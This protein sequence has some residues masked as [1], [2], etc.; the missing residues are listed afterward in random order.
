[1]SCQSL[2]TTR[3]SL[4]RLLL[5]LLL[6]Q[7]L[8]TSSSGGA[9][10]LPL[11]LAPPLDEGEQLQGRSE[12]RATTTTTKAWG[13]SLDGGGGDE[14]TSRRRGV[15]VPPP[16]R[17]SSLLPGGRTV[18]HRTEA[19]EGEEATLAQQDVTARNVR[20]GSDSNDGTYPPDKSAA[21]LLLRAGAG[22]R[23]YQNKL[24]V[25]EGGPPGTHGY[26]ASLSDPRTFVPSSFLLATTWPRR[27]A[28]MRRRRIHRR[29]CCYR[30]AASH[31]AAFLSLC[32]ERS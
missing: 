9:L 29:C 3:L 32:V 8:T 2:G 20:E 17:G 14:R 18:E 28:A 6:L 12:E 23:L 5:L 16:L 10:P 15:D 1:M 31:L 11:P 21:A 13:T 30:R 24:L 22:A 19:E 27:T 26:A 4:L 25:A 7:L